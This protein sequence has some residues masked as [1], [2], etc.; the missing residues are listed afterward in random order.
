MPSSLRSA[1]LGLLSLGLCSA[2]LAFR[3]A[4]VPFVKDEATAPKARS[5]VATD[6]AEPIRYYSYGQMVERL[7]RLAAEAPQFVRLYDAQSRYG[8]PSP[9]SC[10]NADGQTT[11]CLHWVVELSN[12]GGAYAAG[13]PANHS[14]VL[15]NDLA[16][17]PQVFLSGNL[18]G[19]EQVG[20][21]TMIYALEHLVRH[22]VAGDNAWVNRMLDTRRLIV[23]PMTNP[24]GYQRMVRTENG[25]DPNRDFPY[26]QQPSKCML[27]L[28][29]RA[30]NEVWRDNLITSAI[31]FHGGMQAI[32]YEWGAD[33]HV[34]GGSESPDDRAQYL[35][36]HI[37]GNMAGAYRGQRYPVER[38][39]NLV[40]AVDGGMEDWAYAGSWD[41]R[42]VRPCAPS[43]YSGY[44]PEKTQYNDAVLRAFNVLIEASDAKRPREADLGS[45]RPDGTDAL[46]VEGPGD[47]HVPRNMRL[48]Y[49]AIDLVAPYVHVTRA[50]FSDNSGNS[51]AG[52]RL[53]EGAALAS[54]RDVDA[55]LSRRRYDAIQQLALQ[56]RR[57]LMNSTGSNDANNGDLFAARRL[58]AGQGRASLEGYSQVID[59]PP[60]SSS[61]ASG[62]IAACT[63]DA[64]SRHKGAY[65]HW[66]T[67]SAAGAGPAVVNV[68]VGWDVGGCVSIDASSLV[69][70]R[71]DARLPP[72]LL[73]SARVHAE[74][75][76]D[77]S[78]SDDV[79]SAAA[80]ALT[81]S[82]GVPQSEATD[83]I[84]RLHAWQLFLA[85]RVT[86][87]QMPPGY[88]LR[89][90]APATGV[91]RWVFGDIGSQ[92]A[93]ANL[94]GVTSG[95]WGASVEGSPNLMTAPFLTRFADCL[96][97]SAGGS[98]AA[99]SDVV[100][101]GCD[102]ASAPSSPHPNRQRQLQSSSHVHALFAVP[103][104][105]VDSN[106][107]D[108]A[109]PDPP[110]TPPQSHMV[111]ARTT[112]DWRKESGDYV[113]Q[114]RLHAVAQPLFIGVE[115]TGGGGGGDGTPAVTPSAAASV[116]PSPAAPSVSSSLTSSSSPQPP[117]AS[118]S[119]SNS[120]APTSSASGAVTS[121]SSVA[122][123]ASGSSN[124]DA[125]PSSSTAASVPADEGSIGSGSGSPAST[126]NVDNNGAGS[127]GAAAAA[128]GG[129]GGWGIASSSGVQAAVGT[130]LTALV[131]FYAGGPVIRRL[132]STR[133]SRSTAYSSSD[134]NRAAAAAGGRG[135]PAGASD[136]GQLGDDELSEE[137]RELVVHHGW[138]SR[139]RGRIARAPAATTAAAARGETATAAGDDDAPSGSGPSSRSSSRQ[140]GAH[141]SSTSAATAAAV[142]PKAGAGGRI[143]LDSEDDSDGGV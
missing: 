97:I 88:V 137:G 134:S 131:L 12:F 110:D 78:A 20:P 73:T 9:G 33:N 100:L 55:G 26:N 77:P 14:Q 136:D 89:H 5:L 105:V 67:V 10:T 141:K 30:V 85:G 140:R 21:M 86:L 34:G 90:T 66:S 37:M 58:T 35:T 61:P 138:S 133:R 68:S 115:V 87:A 22:R 106:W 63:G 31:T 143:R 47:G 17:R 114:G 25:L 92:P 94:E 29:A 46:L 101:G 53:A 43:T 82:Y 32:S 2:A 107:R 126:S 57:Q 56:R 7:Q 42:Y 104:A 75:N 116:S 99:A 102:A 64:C 120:A 15:A 54:V 112:S 119:S 19:D 60:S 40:Y 123:P 59:G 128:D 121:S 62:A 79:K 125:S 36:S 83:V 139:G 24:L 51:G 71:W 113:V 91:S 23:M 72:H 3:S 96:S 118:S 39:N 111:N 109:N 52:R 129:S 135:A 117:P 41:S 28:T 11:P 45:F 38:I 142:R 8:L 76:T 48:V 130:A 1:R 65:T 6:G 69:V 132:R 13:S 74:G 4:F 50:A 98:D 70:G 122:P 16:H 44:P 93:N 81:S 95:S 127:G 124:S 84:N 80:A 27:T 103:Y 108:Q 49:S 18:H